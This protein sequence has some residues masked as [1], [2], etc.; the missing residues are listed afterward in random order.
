MHWCVTDSTDNYRP[1][2]KLTEIIPTLVCCDW[3][4]EV[5]RE[6]QPLLLLNRNSGLKPSEHLE[7]LI[8]LKYSAKLIELALFFSSISL[9]LRGC[10]REAQH[11]AFER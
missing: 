10:A 9:R 7:I 5:Q 4:I 11:E 3:E 8:S 2:G 1:C 6:S